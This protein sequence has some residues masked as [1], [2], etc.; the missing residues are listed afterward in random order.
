MLVSPVNYRVRA[1]ISVDGNKFVNFGMP[2]WRKQ[3]PGV[4][5]ASPSAP[6]ST[7]PD[8]IKRLFQSPSVFI[9]R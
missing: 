3:I 9:P 7:S 1:S 8:V 2:W 6:G 4:G 5:Y